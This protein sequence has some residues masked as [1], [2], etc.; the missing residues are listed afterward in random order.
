MS[1][2]ADTRRKAMLIQGAAHVSVLLGW[3]MLSRF[4]IPPQFLPPPSAIAV[5]FVTT[6]RSG[7]LPR[8]LWQT[9][10]VLLVGFGLAIVSG[11]AV[12]IAMGTFQMLRR[13]LNPYVNA[14]YAM[15]TVAMVPLVI[16]WL[17][18]GYEAKVFLTWLVAVFPVIINAQIGVMNVSPAFIETARAFGCNDGRP[19]AAWCSTPQCR[20]SSPA[21]DWGWA[22][23]WSALS[24]PRC[25]R[26]CPASAI[27]WCSTAIRSGPLNCSCR[28]SCSLC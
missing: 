19:S 14:F 20:S 8:Q 18:L 9:T 5:A 15:P 3:E 11:M 21:S 23:R 28:S 4:V 13:V 24:S 17:G 6:I 25:S 22:A 27:W 12:G 10:S 2:Q 26:R 16:I 1:V 7:E